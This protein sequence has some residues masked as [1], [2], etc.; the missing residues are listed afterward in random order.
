[1]SHLQRDIGVFPAVLLWRSQACVSWGMGAFLLVMNGCVFLA[2]EVN[3]SW[4][5]RGPHPPGATRG[6]FKALSALSHEQGGWWL[7][8]FWV[9][10]TIRD[11]GS[12]G[13]H[14]LVGFP[15]PSSVCFILWPI[16][17]FLFGGQIWFRFLKNHIGMQ[18]LC[19]VC[20]PI[21]SAVCLFVLFIMVLVRVLNLM[22]S[23]RCSLN[24][25]HWTWFLKYQW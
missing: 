9:F 11:G 2:G 16:F 7:S 25:T 21:F 10:I 3:P 13:T 5:V 1:M 12:S 6:T 24:V 19:Q 22:W 15:V 14:W 8:L 17:Y 23:H 18:A 4:V 20:G